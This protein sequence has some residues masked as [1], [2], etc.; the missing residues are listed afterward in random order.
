MILIRCYY[1]VLIFTQ[2]ENPELISPTV[3][4]ESKASLKF[5]VQRIFLVLKK[6]K[7]S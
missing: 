6:I 1:L 7:L 5:L 4:E 2:L 3:H